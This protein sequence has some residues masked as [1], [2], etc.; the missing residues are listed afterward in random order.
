MHAGRTVGTAHRA[1]AKRMLQIR[2]R[3][4]LWKSILGWAVAIG[5]VLLAAVAAASA[6]SY[7]DLGP[8]PESGDSGM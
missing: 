2:N 1:K 6:P 3:K 4:A 8:S 7:G 5:V